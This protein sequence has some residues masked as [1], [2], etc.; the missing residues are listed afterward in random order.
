M[1]FSECIYSLCTLF[2]IRVCSPFPLSVCPSS[3]HLVEILDCIFFRVAPLRFAGRQRAMTIL[4]GAGLTGIGLH[5]T[6]G[7]EQKRAE[8][9]GTLVVSTLL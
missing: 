6:G 9:E 8:K 5:A 4:S 1:V 7:V 3:F 2:S